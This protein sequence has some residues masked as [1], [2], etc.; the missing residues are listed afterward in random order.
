[1]LG[2]EENTNNIKEKCIFFS[3]RITELYLMLKEEVKYYYD[4]QLRQR[5]DQR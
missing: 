2:E 3:K 5:A 1:M 4:K